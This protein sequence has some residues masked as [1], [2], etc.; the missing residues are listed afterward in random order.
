MAKRYA[1]LKC[2]D[3]GKEIIKPSKT[4]DGIRCECGGAVM[5]TK[6]TSHKEKK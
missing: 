1:I 2:I 6:Y 4:C 5:E 3:C